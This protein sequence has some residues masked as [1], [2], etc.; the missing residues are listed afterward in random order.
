MNKQI[1]QLFLVSIFSIFLAFQTATAQSD[2]NARDLVKLTQWF[3]GEF[4][5]DSQIWYENRYSWK[6]NPEERHHR[7]HTFH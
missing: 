2:P 4:D 3:E 1:Y 7:I 5:N 6:G